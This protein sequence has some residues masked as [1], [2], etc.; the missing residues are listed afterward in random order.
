MS[1]Y[2][3]FLIHNSIKLQNVTQLELFATLLKPYLKSH[4]KP[5]E[6]KFYPFL[7]MTKAY[8]KLK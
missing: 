5:L 2:V 8:L 3:L 1:D 6:F 4:I 7:C